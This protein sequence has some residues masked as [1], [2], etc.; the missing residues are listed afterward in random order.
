MGTLHQLETPALLL[1]EA[2]MDRNIA[3][4]RSRLRQHFGAC[5]I[6]ENNRRRRAR[7]GLR[8]LFADSG[9]ATDSFKIARHKREGFSKATLARAQPV[10]RHGIRRITSEVIAAEALDGEDRA[11]F[12]QVDRLVDGVGALDA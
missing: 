4:M 9:E 3:R 6:E 8:L 10:D 11:R 12:Q 1:D 7:Q 2:Q 5:C